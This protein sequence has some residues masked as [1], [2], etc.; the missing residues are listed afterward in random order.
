MNGCMG[1]SAVIRIL[2]QLHRNWRA[3]IVLFLSVLVMACQTDKSTMAQSLFAAEHP[4]VT[5]S[6]RTLRVG[7]NKQY[8]K[9]SQA[10]AAARD[11]DVIELD[12]V[13]YLGDAAV[14]QAHN[15]TIRG[16]GG[17]AHLKT[18][19][20]NAEDKD[21]WVIKGNNT[22]IENIEFSGAVV[23]DTN[24]AG[25]RQERTGLTV[26]HCYFHHNQMGILTGVNLKSDIL[27][28]HSE[29]A[30]NGDQSGQTHNIYIGQ[31]RS[32]T[33]RY[34]YSHHAHIGHLVKSRAHTN[35][36]LYNRLTDEAD[37]DSSYN[38]D[39]PNGGVS[40]IIGNIIQQSPAT[41]NATLVAFAL[42]GPTNP[43]QELYVINNTFVNDLQIGTFI[44]VKRPPAVMK[45]VNNLFVGNGAVFTGA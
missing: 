41:D 5:P 37:G 18:N 15:L 32:F 25:V 8:I 11:G 12:P 36:I 13:V 2:K 38:I 21:I 30:W 43:L 16:V 10:V 7:P 3:W 14:W 45:V 26:R 42:E 27:I 24:G 19:G 44:Q 4:H 23:S 6:S 39:L 28:E 17:T 31:V 1:K 33:L 9:P 40:Y 35:Y 34:S 29:F 22:T 20:A